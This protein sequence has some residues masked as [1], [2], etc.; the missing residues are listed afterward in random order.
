MT[1]ADGFRSQIPVLTIC[2]L[3]MMILVR[4]ASPRLGF[5]LALAAGWVLYLAGWAA[6]RAAVHEK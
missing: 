6:L 5:G 4:L 2:L 1:T 3:P